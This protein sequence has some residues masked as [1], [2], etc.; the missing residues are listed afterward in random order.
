MSF[1]NIELKIKRI[2]LEGHDLPVPVGLSEIISNGNAWGIRG[3]KINPDYNR[4]VI[5]RD[6]NLI[7]VLK[8]K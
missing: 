1:N 3:G 6:G 8:K 4:E 5:K 7:T 2:T